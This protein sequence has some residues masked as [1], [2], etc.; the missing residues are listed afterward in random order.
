MCVDAL[1]GMCLWVYMYSLGGVCVLGMLEAWFACSVQ[2]TNAAA[3][4][5]Q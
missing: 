1:E 5:A 2:K 3:G 4:P